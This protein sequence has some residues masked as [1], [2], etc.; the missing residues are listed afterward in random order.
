MMQHTIV[1]TKTA[2]THQ[3]KCSVCGYEA[4]AAAHTFV[5]KNND[6]QYWQECSVCGYA[7]NIITGT[8]TEDEWKS[9]LN[10]ENV[11]N[12]HSIHYSNYNIQE[13]KASETAISS[14][15]TNV[16]DN[17]LSYKKIYVVEGTGASEAVYKY[18][19][20]KANESDLSKD[21]WKKETVAVVKNKLFSLVNP[22][23]NLSTAIN[24]KNS[25]DYDAESGTYVSKTDA[26]GLK[27]NTSNLLSLKLKFANAKLVWFEYTLDMTDTQPEYCVISYNETDVELPTMT[28][29]T[30]EEWQ[31]ALSF[32]GLT[33]YTINLDLAKTTEIIS[34]ATTKIKYEKT[35][36]DTIYIRSKSL[37]SFEYL[38]DSDLIGNPIYYTTI[39]ENTYD[40]FE[41]KADEQ[42]YY[43]AQAKIK[44]ATVQDV[45]LT[46]SN[47]RLTKI[48]YT[49]NNDGEYV[50]TITYTYNDTTITLPT[51]SET[52]TRPIYYSDFKNFKYDGVSLSAGENVFLIEISDD[53]HKT[54]KVAGA[55]KLYV[56][57]YGTD[58]NSAT[59]TSITAKN[60]LGTE[61]T[62]KSSVNSYMQYEDL[63]AGKYYFTITVTADCVGNF[64]VAFL[65]K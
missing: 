35:N 46:F 42:V 64:Y 18:T 56:S 24:A 39:F 25:F 1:Y 33:N 32:N 11:T 20:T 7:Q 21:V 65:T 63:S 55:Y 48:Q 14:V 6:T 15:I 60:A 58:S 36:S 8:V 50:N 9:A 23:S 43:I 61:L 5:T 45:K 41:Y 44:G 4:D 10:F 53:K 40:S 49:T 29:V 22:K 13:V 26:T 47:R 27:Y 30:A 59:T 37:S 19:Y 54:L 57:F 34:F 2:T 28:S 17:S 12:F 52:V 16:S 3:A 31:K 51:A 62:N 38:L